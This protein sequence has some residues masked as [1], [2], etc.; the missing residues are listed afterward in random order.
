[1]SH[2]HRLHL[3]QF[4]F[5]LNDEN[6]LFKASGDPLLF[7][8]IVVFRDCKMAR[9]SNGYPRFADARRGGGHV[10]AP[11]PLSS[12]QSGQNRGH[13]RHAHH[14]SFFELF[15]QLSQRIAGASF[16][17]VA[18]AAEK[19]FRFGNLHFLGSNDVVDAHLVESFLH[20][21]LL[22]RIDDRRVVQVAGVNAL[23]V[24]Q[25]QQAVFL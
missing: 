21:L 17:Q 16:H 4:K 14:R 9:L 20:L 19:L 15:L 2:H 24:K 13:Q 3:L 12:V 8:A 5:G 18:A 10:Q 25:N 11:K 1:M 23:V 22:V 7:V 6:V